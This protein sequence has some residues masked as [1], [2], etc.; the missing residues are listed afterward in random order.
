M[1]WLKNISIFAKLIYIQMLNAITVV[2]LISAT[3]V[4]VY[5]QERKIS[6][7]ENLKS[8]TKVIATKVSSAI[9]F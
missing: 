5:F 4:Y 9:L 7:V 2:L 6:K 1:N 8:L 3:Y